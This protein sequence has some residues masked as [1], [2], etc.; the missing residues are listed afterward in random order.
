MCPMVHG[1]PAVAEISA[2]AQLGV[3]LLQNLGRHLANGEVADSWLNVSPEGRF[4]SATCAL[5]HVMHSQPRLDGGIKGRFGRCVL[6]LIDFGEQPSQD[7]FV[8]GPVVNGLCEV[9]V[10][11]RQRI[12]AC[13][14]QNLA[15]VA[16]ASDVATFAASSGQRL[17]DRHIVLNDRFNDR[18]QRRQADK[19]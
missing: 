17:G 12:N 14:N 13:V 3:E 10:S 9:V 8:L 5:F 6:L 15:L 19:A 16:A 11:S 1:R 7:L 18:D 2:A 4:V